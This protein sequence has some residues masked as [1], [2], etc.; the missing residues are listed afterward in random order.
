MFN[1]I[2][3]RYDFLNSFLSFGIHR[4]WRKKTIRLLNSASINRQPSFSIIDVATGTG[5]FAIDALA[6]KPAKV[7]GVDISEKMLLEARKKIQKLNLSGMIEL[8][9]ADSENLPF[10][11]ES[12]EAAIVG[13]GVRNFENLERGLS[14]IARVLK[15]NGILAVLEFSMP[16]KFPIKQLYH[17][18]LKNLCPFIGRIISKNPV[19]Y[20]YLFQSVINFPYGKNFKSILLNN[21]FSRAWY[22]PQTFGIVTIYLATK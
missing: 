15:K 2:A 17:F 7:T 13:F 8:Q 19:A 9:K 20:C 22:Y 11:D 21:G 12:F 16:E 3:F 5:D 4:Y 10:T 1:E 6:L 18:Y 14:E